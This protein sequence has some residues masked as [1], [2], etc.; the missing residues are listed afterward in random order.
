VNPRVLSILKY[1]MS[2]TRCNEREEGLTENIRIPILNVLT[3]MVAGYTNGDTE[4][5]TDESRNLQFLSTH[6]MVC[7][8]IFF[9]NPH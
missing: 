9:Q 8:S 4:Q 7:M 5:E 1:Q 2:N 3:W 6:A